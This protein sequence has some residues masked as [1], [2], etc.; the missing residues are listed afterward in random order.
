[1]EMPGDYHAEW[2]KWDREGEILYDTS[3]MQNLIRNYTNELI[4]KTERLIDL[5]NEFM[6][7]RWEE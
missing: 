2:S 4:Y 6:V 7:A 3:F 5:E 1:M